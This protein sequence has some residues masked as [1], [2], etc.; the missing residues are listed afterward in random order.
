M[1]V[2][3]KGLNPTRMQFR[4]IFGK[5]EVTDKINPNTG[6]PIK[7]FNDHFKKWGGQYSLTQN[8][9]ITLAGAGIKNATVFFIRHDEQ[10]TSD[11]LIKKGNDIYTIDSI[12]YDDGLPVD[13]YDLITCHK[14]VVK[15]D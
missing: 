11:Y 7:G 10:V 15:H 13:G 12:T 1:V 9:T 6:K 5:N 4:L 8:Q 3:M 2:P 14:E